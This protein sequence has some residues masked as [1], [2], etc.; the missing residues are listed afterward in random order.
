V[1]RSVRGKILLRPIIQLPKS[2]GASVQSAQCGRVQPEQGSF[3]WVGG[4]S[5]LVSARHC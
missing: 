3:P 4:P 5:P 2:A 1:Q